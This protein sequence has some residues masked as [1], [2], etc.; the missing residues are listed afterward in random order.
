MANRFKHGYYDAKD[1]V[2]YIKSDC[3]LPNT[4][5]MTWQDHCAAYDKAFKMSFEERVKAYATDEQREAIFA[6][7]AEH[8]GATISEYMDVHVVR[9]AKEVK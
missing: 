5:D 3:L 7:L 6:F 4:D 2:V 8:E 9:V 1:N